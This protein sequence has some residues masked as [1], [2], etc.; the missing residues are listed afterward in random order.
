MMPNLWNEVKFLYEF[1]RFTKV[2]RKLSKIEQMLDSN[3]QHQAVIEL[4][5]IADIYKI[6]H[7]NLSIPQLVNVVTLSINHNIDSLGLKTESN[8]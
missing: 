4:E 3:Q 1:Y 7:D 5:S 2:L 8:S 6:N